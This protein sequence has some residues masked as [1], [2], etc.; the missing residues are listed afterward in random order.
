MLVNHF[1][2]NKESTAKALTQYLLYFL[3]KNISLQ[4]E[5]FG[6]Y[7]HKHIVWGEKWGTEACDIFAPCAPYIHCC[8]PLQLA[9]NHAANDHPEIIRFFDA[10]LTIWKSFHYSP[11]KME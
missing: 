11:K 9:D 8:H 5:W 6:V 2:D 10:L 3:R 7:W 1:L 4:A